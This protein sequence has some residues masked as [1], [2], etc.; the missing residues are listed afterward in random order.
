[1]KKS[2]PAQPPAIDLDALWKSIIMESP[3]DFVELSMPEL[4]RDID[5]SVAPIFLQQEFI[6]SL[7]GKYKIKGKRKYSDILAQFTLKTGE[8]QYLYLH[9]E[10]QKAL[11][12]AF[13]ERMFTYMSLA[14]LRYD[15]ANF[16]ALGVFIG[17]APKDNHAQYEWENYG[18]KLLYRFNVLS[19]AK[20][21]EAI[22]IASQNP[23]AL[24]ILAAKY[25][26]ET[27][28]DSARRF[29]FK[30]KVFEL[31]IAR[32]IPRDKI[33][34]M[35]TFV[36]EIMDLPSEL[37]HLFNQEITMFE[38]QYPETI[39]RTERSMELI[40]IFYKNRTGKTIQEEMADAIA[41]AVAEKEAEKK[42][43]KEAERKAVILKLTNEL[44]FSAE[45]IA[46]LMGYDLT[47][48]QETIAEA[49][50]ER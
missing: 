2:K 6:N 42:V 44:Q 1:M 33:I 38:Q 23:F 48:V 19:I 49:S 4:H 15:R 12:S 13:G 5:W 40:N 16:T 18:T 21:D 36:Y 41:D 26:I 30:R 20:Q 25:T 10:V 35:L 50:N 28:G 8:K 31:A 46:D 47:F 34:R 9:I 32:K 43:E 37:H 29:A 22:L 24:V 45:K 14:K 17:D 27:K 11:E 3:D 39:Y 7:K